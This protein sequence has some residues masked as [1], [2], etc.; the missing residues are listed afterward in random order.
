MPG[1]RVFVCNKTC[2][3]ALIICKF[4]LNDLIPNNAPAAYSS[5]SLV[6]DSTI[7]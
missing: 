2:F 7:L 3:K 5:I 4:K 1:Q 6:C